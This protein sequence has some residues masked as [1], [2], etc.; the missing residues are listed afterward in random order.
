MKKLIVNRDEARLIEDCDDKRT[1]TLRRSYKCF[2]LDPR[3][4][5][6]DRV[7]VG[8]VFWVAEPICSIHLGGKYHKEHF[9]A[10]RTPRGWTRYTM[11]RPGSRVHFGEHRFKAKVVA[12][13]LIPLSFGGYWFQADLDLDVWEVQK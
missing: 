3:D 6:R 10:D 12:I 11:S 1:V 2:N 13:R 8:D 7:K 5:I 4:V 9:E